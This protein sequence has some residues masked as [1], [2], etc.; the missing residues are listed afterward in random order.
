MSDPC[1]APVDAQHML[2]AVGRL[3][4]A[5]TIATV[6]F[7]STTGNTFAA[8]KSK[9]KPYSIIIGTVWDQHGRAVPGVKVKIQRVGDKHPKWEHVSDNNGEFAQRFPAG[10][11]DYVI[12]AELKGKKGHIAETKVHVDNDERQDV[13]LHL[14]E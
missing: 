14:P 3:V 12:W 5:L 2:C 11:A 4:L 13:G 6:V 9:L 10:Q 8:E 1:G 7:V